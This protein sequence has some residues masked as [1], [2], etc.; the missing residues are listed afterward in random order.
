MI[1][2]G[3]MDLEHNHSI[4]NVSDCHVLGCKLHCSAHDTS[5]KKLFELNDIFMSLPSVSLKGDNDSSRVD[6][7]DCCKSGLWVLPDDVLLNILTILRPL[8]LLKISAT[9]HH[10]RF[11]AASIMPCMKLKLFPHQHAAVEWMLRRERDSEVLPHPL[12]M[13][14]L[15]ED[16]FPF[17]V[18]V[19]SGEI[20]SN[21]KPTFRDFKGGMF[22]DEPG[23]GK[24]ITALSLI[25]KTQGTLA[26]PPDGTQ[27]IW[28][29]HNGDQ[30][31]GYYELNAGNTVSCKVSSS[32]GV[33][34]ETA[35]R[36]QFSLD[37]LSSNENLNGYSKKNKFAVDVAGLTE[38]QP[39]EEVESPK[40]AHSTP[41]TCVVRCT[42]SSSGV[43]KN[44]LHKFATASG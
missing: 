28:C 39:H 36:G 11:L 42:R 27:V 32:K 7:V 16:G 37:K 8:E 35:R 20:I 34:S 40:A 17:Y 5:K 43:K 13:D 31:C 4:W 21:T 6:P 3:K 19:V 30:R 24:T 1:E 2:H 25:L 22:C 26:A 14:F 41:A 23:L 12:F 33:V 15:T 44:L 18:N 10:L 29:Y 38:L 9:C